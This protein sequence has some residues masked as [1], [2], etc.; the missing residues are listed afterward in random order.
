MLYKIRQYCTPSTLRTLYF[1]LF[2]SHL[3]YGLAVWGNAN[4]VHINRIKLL[5]KRAIR[6]IS[7]STD[8]FEKLLHDLKILNFDDQLKV[9]LSSL[10]WDYDHGIIPSSLKDLFKRSNLVHNYRTRGASKGSLYYCKVNT[11]KY[12]IKSFKYQGIHILNNLKK[13]SFYKNSKVKSKFLKQLKTYLLAEYV[14][15]INY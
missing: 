12:G 3:T 6:A 1:S 5:Q 13:L 15:D 4:A 14:N 10:M 8:D 7:N 2:H 11:T 9:Q